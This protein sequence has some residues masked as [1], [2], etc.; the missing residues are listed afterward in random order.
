MRTTSASAGGRKR[1][2]SQEDSCRT[3]AT[4]QVERQAKRRQLSK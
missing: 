3:A 1:A 2:G 4:D